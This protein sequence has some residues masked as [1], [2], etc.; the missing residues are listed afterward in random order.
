VNGAELGVV[1]GAL[2]RFLEVVAICCASVNSFRVVTRSSVGAQE[3]G[4]LVGVVVG[5]AIGMDGWPP[6]RPPPP[7]PPPLPPPPY[8]SAREGADGFLWADVHRC[9]LRRR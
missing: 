3:E 9:V 5:A 1:V 7:L 2:L 6:P 8:V 4:A